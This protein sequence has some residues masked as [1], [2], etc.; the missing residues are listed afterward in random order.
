MDRRQHLVPVLDDAEV[1]GAGPARHVGAWQ[2][3]DPVVGARRWE[4]RIFVREEHAGL[5]RDILD[6]KTPRQEA[7]DAIFDDAFPALSIGLHRGAIERRAPV[8]VGEDPA[9]AGRQPR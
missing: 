3:T 5:H 9:I 4:Y 8:F 2:S 6:A 7:R 1:P